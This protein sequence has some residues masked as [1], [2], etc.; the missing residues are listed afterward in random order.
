MVN[1]VQLGD[2]RRDE[3]GFFSAERARFAG[4]RIQAGHGDSRSVAQA[5]AQKI[6]EQSAHAH[7]FF[8]RE[9]FRYPTKRNVSGDE[10]H[11]ELPARQ[12]HGEIFHAAAFGE[13]FRLAGK[14]ETDFVHARF[15]NG[16]GDD[17][18]EFTADR[19]GDRFFQRGGGGARRSCSR[20]AWV[21]VR[22]IT[23]DDEFAVRKRRRFQC[24][25]HDFR[26]DP[27]RVAEGDADSQVG[28]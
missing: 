28:D 12:E 5:A 21:T 13:K 11:G 24:R 3:G 26:A 20:F 6:R 22:I 16:A 1:G 27:R 17:R 7:D 8:L 23:D 25:G 9:D 15:V 2:R 4:V 14:L 18:G 10:R 19:S